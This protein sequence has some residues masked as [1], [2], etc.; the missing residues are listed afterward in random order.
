LDIGIKL[1][2]ATNITGQIQRIRNGG[3]IVPTPKERE[4]QAD[5][6]LRS[7]STSREEGIDSTIEETPDPTPDI[8]PSEDDL[9]AKLNTFYKS[10]LVDSSDFSGGS[11]HDI[12]Y[13]SPSSISRLLHLYG[14]GKKAKRTKP[15]PMREALSVGEGLQV[16]DTSSED[17]II[18]RLQ[19]EGWDSTT[20]PSQ[21]R[22]QERH[23]PRFT[24]DLRPVA[25]LLRT[26][27]SKRCKTCRT[28]LARPEPKVSSNR[29][30][31]RVLALNNIP[32][33]S[34]RSLTSSLPI[35]ASTHPLVAP[36]SQTTTQGFDYT[37]LQPLMPYQ[38]LLTLTNPLFDSIRVTLAT[39]AVTPGR[40]QTRVT[41]L[42]PQFEVGANTD[43]WDEA[44]NSSAMQKRKSLMPGSSLGEE[45][46]TKQPEAGKLWDKGRNWSSVIVEVV[47]G[48]PPGG[49]G[50]I[51]PITTPS[52]GTTLSQTQEGG[53]GKEKGSLELLPDE[54][55]CEIPIF[56]RLE[57]D[58]EA[59]GGGGEE[60]STALKTGEGKERREVAFWC[61]LG[62]GQIVG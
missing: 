51:P 41:I 56:V 58:A 49:A 11:L 61:V 9:F 31:L 3:I 53:K 8:P 62:V 42:C 45:D 47:P 6:L 44:L 60:R 39:P 24:S 20:S 26:K 19:E 2:K 1:D 40:V 25:T 12:N 43:V 13:S 37:K 32:K 7:T 10:Q 30:K 48:T 52:F 23:P 5:R 29:Y 38:F 14:P 18:K 36:S 55:S 57:Y 59:A 22:F 16:F 17:E 28:L 34:I 27:R 46:K 54:D 4:T 33:V 35:T 21:R 50:Y 15:K